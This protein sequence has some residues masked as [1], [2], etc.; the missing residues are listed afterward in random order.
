[1]LKADKYLCREVNH[2][3]AVLLIGIVLLFSEQ[4]A[5][6][7]DWQ[8]HPS[9]SGRVL[10]GGGWYQAYNLGSINASPEFNFPLQLVYI[11]TRVNSGLFGPQWYCPQLES[12]VVPQ[13]EG[14]FLWYTPSGAIDVFRADQGSSSDYFDSSHQWFA[15][16]DSSHQLIQNQEGWLYEY[17]RG[18]LVAVTSPTNRILAFSW[19]GDELTNVQIQDAATGQ[20]VNLFQA[21]YSDA[22]RLTIMAFGTTQHQFAY[23]PGRDGR[24]S[25]WWAPDKQRSSF[26]YADVGILEYIN[27]STEGI[28]TFS[29]ELDDPKLSREDQKNPSHWRLVQD[30][31][32]KYS[33]G[34]DGKVTAQSGTGLTVD[35]D[36][37]LRRGI[38]TETVGGNVRKNYYYRAPGQKYDGKL[39]RVEENGKV[40][41]EYFYDRKTGLLTSMLDEHGAMIHFDYPADWKPS[42]ENPWD[43]KPIRVWKGSPDNPEIMGAFQY[44]ALGHVVAAQ[45]KT[46]QITRYGYDGRNQLA[47][48]TDPHGV[49]TKV[50]YDSLGRPLQTNSGSESK[51][52][53][54]DDKG[55]IKTETSNGIERDYDYDSSG[56]L[57]TISQNGRVVLEYIRDDTGKLTGIKDVLQRLKKVDT[58]KNGNITAEYALDGK[59]CTKYEYD[60][61]NR[62]ISQT[63]GN[64]NKTT[65][66]YDPGSHLTKQTNALG[67]TIKWE[68]DNQGHL[69]TKTTA[70]QTV[71]NTYDEDRLVSTDYGAGQKIT[72]EY[73][74]QGHLL[75]AATPDT[76]CYYVDDAEGQVRAIRYVSGADEQ[77]VRFRYNSAGQ[78]T[79]LLLAHLRSA[80]APAGGKIGKDAQYDIIQQTEYGY[81]EIGRLSSITSCGQPVVTYQYDIQNRLAKKIFGNGMTADF[82]YDPL[83]RLSQI[84]FANGPI[85]SPLTLAYEWDAA[86]QVTRRSWNG[87]TQR[88]EYTTN[89]QLSKVINDKTGDVLESYQYDFAGNMT[90]KMLNGQKTTMSYNAANELTSST[91]PSGSMSF[92]YDKA[93][94]MVNNGTVTKTYGWLD[95]VVSTTGAGGANFSLTYW[96]DGQLAAERPVTAQNPIPPTSQPSLGWQADLRRALAERLS[97]VKPP[98][99][100]IVNDP[101]GTEHFLWDGLALLRRDDNFYITEPQNGGSVIASHPLSDVRNITFYLNDLLG[102][103]LATII[104][105][106][107]TITKL[108][109]FGQMALSGPKASQLQ[110]TP[111]SSPV[112]QIPQI[113]PS[114]TR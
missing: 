23:F 52:V 85:A 30:P 86:N 87:E 101:P 6:A 68:Y 21:G 75:S 34:T 82:S 95:K 98:L 105:D 31:D 47:S 11:N 88:Y 50:T 55:R 54:Y 83:G 7:V 39:R 72:Y 1:M 110:V 104:N 78:R 8:F 40:M 28:K 107:V 112:P 41:A 12:S 67:E 25:E 91:G 114:Q 2:I 64:G 109:S 106:T 90:E 16:F 60:A 57:H 27:D 35:R 97:S 38:V 4:P 63:D 32:Q 33:Y 59:S 19:E 58:D 13:G 111:A 84:V 5:N 29:T 80:V 36:V 108:T 26:T 43:P 65:F 22:K 81:D 56:N 17:R 10:D 37:N 46:G 45:D 92:S 99:T 15:K 74:E 79:G 62:H 51:S 20:G 100:A 89:G 93:G 53:T 66:E 44:D 73:D 77:L 48:V 102:T 70:E 3:C 69:K 61:Y 96:P 49:T 103:S 14:I 94:R 71:K 18:H 24:L 113:P 76:A 42:R 9:S